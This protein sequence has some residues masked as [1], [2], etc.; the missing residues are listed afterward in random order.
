[1]QF[2][3]IH[4]GRWT[5]FGPLNVTRLAHWRSC[6]SLP[7][8]GPLLHDP[9]FCHGYSSDHYAQSW[10]FVCFLRNRHPSAF[11]SLLDAARLPEIAEP[12][13]LADR[14][15]RTI[16]HATASDLP[17]LELSWRAYIRTLQDP[18]VSTTSKDR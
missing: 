3:T 12:P 9:G 11:T 18:S 2:E 10:A 15:T 1:M 4:D 13:L 17:A 5:G 16:L 6:R 8:L 14:L 7:R